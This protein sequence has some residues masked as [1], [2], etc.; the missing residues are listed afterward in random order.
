MKCCFISLGG[1]CTYSFLGG[2]LLVSAEF[3]YNTQ[4]L[5][6]QTQEPSGI[7]KVQTFVFLHFYFCAHLRLITESVS[8]KI[9]NRNGIS[10][11]HVKTL[12]KSNDIHYYK[13]LY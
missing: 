8:F 13:Y 5:D 10:T 6:C 2:L 3:L 7:Y 9:T 4:H 1:K 11:E 12:L